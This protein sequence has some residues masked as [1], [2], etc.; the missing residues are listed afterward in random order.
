MGSAFGCEGGQGKGLNSKMKPGTKPVGFKIRDPEEQREI[1]YLMKIEQ[2]LRRKEMEIQKLEAEMDAVSSRS[3]SYTN[4]CS[5]PSMT[6]NRPAYQTSSENYPS[7]VPNFFNHMEKSGTQHAEH[8]KDHLVQRPKPTGLNNTQEQNRF[9]D[10][11][12]DTLNSHREILDSFPS[13]RRPMENCATQSVPYTEK[14]QTPPR[15]PSAESLDSH[16]T[17]PWKT[18]RKSHPDNPLVILSS[19]N[20]HIT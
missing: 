15:F 11:S 7:D 16:T 18:S 2:D 19:N 20:M 3:E 1:R 5:N 12:K 9:S 14:K 13:S 6:S 8:W 10:E 4:S 17:S